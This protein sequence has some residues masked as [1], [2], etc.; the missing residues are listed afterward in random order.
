MSEQN[1]LNPTASSQMN[2]TYPIRHKDPQIIAS[3]QPRSGKPSQ[4]YMMARGM[5]F[6]LHWEKV[7]FSTYL[8]L[9]QWFR[10]YER[11]FFSY[12]DIDDNRY[13]SGQFL[14]EPQ[15]ERV[16]N[17]QVNISATFVAVPTLPQFQYPSNWGV[18][19]IFIEERDGFGSDLVKLTGTWTFQAVAQAN[20]GGE[21]FS[22]TTN[23]IA[24]WQY[25]GYGFRLWSIKD[26]SR[27]IFQVILDGIDRGVADCFNASLLASAPVFAVTNVNLGLHRVQLRVTGTK[28]AGATGFVCAADV[29]E[30]M[31]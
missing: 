29:I 22:I 21:Y 28:N 14:A 18:D 3:W 24:E 17:N 31:R 25:F 11:D 9:R 12:F 10:Q 4:R 1:I 6:Q 27:G 19:S 30:V 26:V 2:P 15:M 13:Y 16:G 23:D 8:S 20:G 5:E 7:Q